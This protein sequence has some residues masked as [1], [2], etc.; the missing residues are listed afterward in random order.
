MKY[1]KPL[2]EATLSQMT[3]E[4]ELMSMMLWKPIWTFNR[5]RLHHTSNQTWR[6]ILI[7]S[8]TYLLHQVVT[9]G[10]SA[11]DATYM[12]EEKIN[13][14]KKSML[15]I[16]SMVRVK[17]FPLPNFGCNKYRTASLVGSRV[18][19]CISLREFK[20]CRSKQQ[21]LGHTN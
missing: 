14:G 12:L 5:I 18:F 3:S 9:L 2:I 4:E 16:L 11:A 1:K 17:R 8:L 13:S 21:H 20:A 15:E 6:W 19:G 10:K 7:P